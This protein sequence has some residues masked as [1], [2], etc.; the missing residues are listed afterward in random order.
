MKYSCTSSCPGG[1][2]EG[3]VLPGVSPMAWEQV[4][5]ACAEVCGIVIDYE[6]ASVFE[7]W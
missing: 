7:V 3:E 4:L 2:I 1:V 5:D 6:D